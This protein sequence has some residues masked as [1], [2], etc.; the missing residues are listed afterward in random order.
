MRYS[1]MI[2]Q[3]CGRGT[4]DEYPYCANCGSRLEDVTRLAAGPVALG[5]GEEVTVAFGGVTSAQTALPQPYGEDVTRTVAVSGVTAGAPF[6]APTVGPYTDAPTTAPTTALGNAPAPPPSDPSGG[7]LQVGQGFGPRY[8]IIRLLGLGGM[9][10]VYQ[11]WDAELGVA[12][13]VKVI[14]PSVMA[15][16]QVAADVERRFKR[17]LLLARQVTHKNVV[18]IHDLG[19]IAGIKYITMSYVDGV[20]LASILKDEGKLSAARALQIVR[21]VVSGLLAAHA[22]GV[23]HRD[24]KPANIMVSKDGD[25]LIMDFGIARSSG[26]ASE[27]L[28]DRVRPDGVRGPSIRDADH[29]VAGSIMGSVRYMAP[30]QARGQDVDQRA[31]IYAFGLMLYDM[32]AGR[33]RALSAPS[34]M[35]ELHVR[36][37]QPPPPV[38]SLEPAVPEPLDQLIA[39]CVLP[40]ANERYQ[41]TIELAAD[42][43]RLD[44]NGELIP[45][46]KVVGLP[47]VAAG[48]VL[49]AGLI[50]WT[51]FATRPEPPPPPATSV[52]IADFENRANEPVFTGTVESALGIALEGAS[53][54][55]AY[56]REDAQKALDLITPGATLDEAGAKLLSVRE[57]IKVVLAGSIETRGS[58]YTLS[59]R[60][61]DPAVDKVLSTATARA[62]SRDDVMQAVAA[63]ASDIR[64][65]LGDQTPE[66][67]KLAAAETVTAAS[68]ESLQHYMRGQALQSDSKYDESIESYKRAIA[69][70]PKFGRAY[71]AWA[72]SAYSLGRRDESEGLYKQAFALMERMSEREKYRT[73]GTYYLTLA[74]NYE[75]AIDNYTTLL[76][77]YPADRAARTNL[78]ISYF[79]TRDF[80]RA[81][82][83]NRRALD[84]YQG[85]FKLWSNHALYAMYAGDFATAEK[86]GGHV[87]AES[88]TYYRAYLPLAI[89]ALARSDLAG[90][91]DAYAKMATTDRQGTSLAAMGQADV[92]MF[93]GRFDEADTTLRRALE[94]DEALK[95][96]AAIAAKTI[97]LAEALEA[98]GQSRAAVAAVEAAL[99]TSRDE[100]TLVP[101]ARMLARLNQVEAAKKLAAELDSRLQPQSRAYAKI[102]DGEVAVRA[103]RYGEAVE[104]Y[105][106]GQ[107]LADLWLTRF[108]LG[109]AFV[110]A[111]H[112]AEGLAELEV[113]DKRRGEATAVF[114]DDV[115]SYRYL[116]TLPYWLA[117]AQEGL[118]QKPA[119]VENYKKFA[120]IRSAAARD[121]LAQDAAKRL[122]SL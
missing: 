6:D 41:T 106:A 18:R 36:M 12:V 62:G 4:P 99:R 57:G 1:H 8:H 33:A 73:Y 122:G 85:S 58:G 2:C 11:A 120:A 13:A 105:R 25:A 48:L 9:G 72:V 76:K 46:R 28:G 40:D 117:R 32:L 37:A 31:D 89:S 69:S 93:E 64:G 47:A 50:G 39:R 44:D 81:L 68:L 100:S 53:F 111:G 70:D 45:I 17:E 80:A 7:P 65:A 61:I 118:G 77:L 110:L 43:D 121:P 88:P 54:I 20:D 66:S 107:K 82:E 112:Y 74:R 86:E 14:L 95:N 55:T 29:T 98:R 91:H 49:S 104:A 15:D 63:L 102:I 114:L 60:A 79:Y 56:R 109:V 59:V 3:A 21:P 26:G 94:G 75:Q 51:W 16:R 90:A 115:P 10:A 22:A 24:L 52:L 19:E 67:A 103:G 35:A 30:E 97:A 83:E 84:I 87:L 34:A 23:V 101:A 108:G 113:C 92:L 27:P 116:A 42:L 71:A 5:N 119:A 96:P 38:R 78:A